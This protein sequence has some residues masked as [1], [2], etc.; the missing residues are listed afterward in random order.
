MPPVLRIR[1]VT[2]R[3]K[4]TVEKRKTGQKIADSGYAGQ[5]GASRDGLFLCVSRTE[6]SIREEQTCADG[7][8]MDRNT[9][10][11]TGRRV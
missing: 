4:Q 6:I 3:Q 9:I 11:E 2:V 5:D 8:K 10:A 7:R 1:A